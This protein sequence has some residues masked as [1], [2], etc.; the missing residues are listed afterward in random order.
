MICVFILIFSLFCVRLYEAEGNVSPEIQAV[1]NYALEKIG[2]CT[3][4]PEQLYLSL[5]V[6]LI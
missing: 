4:N 2:D 5:R 1:A 3:G 6:C